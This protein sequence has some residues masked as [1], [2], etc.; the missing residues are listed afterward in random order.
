M[1]VPAGVTTVTALGVF[2]ERA[3]V[4]SIDVNVR[5]GE[6]TTADFTLEIMEMDI[7]GAAGSN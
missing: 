4:Q 5:G 3:V 1:N 6:T 7:T 2:Q